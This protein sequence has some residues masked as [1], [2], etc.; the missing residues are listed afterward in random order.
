MSHE[1]KPSKSQNRR[2]HPQ[3]QRRE[4]IAEVVSEVSRHVPVIVVD[5]GSSDDSIDRLAA[6]DVDIVQHPTNLGKGEALKSGFRAALAQNVD[7]V[8]TLDADG[9]HA[10]EDV[11]Q[12]VEAYTKTRTS[13]IIGQRDFRQMPFSRRLANTLGQ[14]TLQAALGRLI[15]DNQSGFRLID[16]YLVEAM[17]DNGETGFEFEVEMILFCVAEK[18]P[19]EWVPIRTIYR[20]ETSHIKPIQHVIKYVSLLRRAYQTRRRMSANL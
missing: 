5:D 16:R 6:L 15:P 14:Q 11:P 19:I 2:H 10:P 13:L 9:Q 12:F 8:I 17:L 20:D 4:H 1:N 18:I 7:A 3:L